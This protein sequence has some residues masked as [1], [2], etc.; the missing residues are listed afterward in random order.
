MRV[1]FKGFLEGA[2]QGLRETPRG[3]LAPALA[4]FRWLFLVTDR[5]IRRA[6]TRRSKRQRLPEQ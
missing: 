6:N 1:F 5:E 3:Y 4:F 2:A